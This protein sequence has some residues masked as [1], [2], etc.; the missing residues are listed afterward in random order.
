MARLVDGKAKIPDAPSHCRSG[1]VRQ[2][3]ALVPRARAQT[4]S[5]RPPWGPGES[6]LCGGLAPHPLGLGT[7]LPR[8]PRPVQRTPPDPVGLGQRG[9]HCA[10]PPALRRPPA[11][12]G[13]CRPPAGATRE[14]RGLGHLHLQGPPRRREPHAASRAGGHGR[15][16]G[17]GAQPRVGVSPGLHPSAGRGAGAGPGGAGRGLV[18]AQVS[19]GVASWLRRCA[20]RG[21]WDGVVGSGEGATRSCGGGRESAIELR[22]RGLEEARGRPGRARSQ[23]A[24][25]GPGGRDRARAPQ[26]ASVGRLARKGAYAVPVG[27]SLQV[28]GV[29]LAEENQRDEMGDSHRLPSPSQARAPAPA[30]AAARVRSTCESRV[31]G[32]RSGVGGTRDSRGPGPGGAEPAVRRSGLHGPQEAPPAV[33]GGPC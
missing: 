4:F 7:Q 17:P 25:R 19:G 9:P 20:G 5:G 8:L 6:L 3:H 22:A 32:A 1:G 28:A 10:A 21:P 16:Q 15:L 31:P 18:A 13:P 29:T 26:D 2:A 11:F 33:L 14:R 12:P 27:Q 24:V 23:G 30:A